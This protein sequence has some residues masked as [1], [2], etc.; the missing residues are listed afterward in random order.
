MKRIK[1]F[2]DFDIKSLM[3]RGY[4]AANVKK[5]SYN[6]AFDKIYNK[7]IEDEG[8][9]PRPSGEMNEG[10]QLAYTYT[11]KYNGLFQKL[12]GLPETESFGALYNYFQVKFIDEI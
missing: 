5:L 10:Q 8:H 9:F 11:K 2:E 7:I 4:H 12:T 6:E 1:S 3:K